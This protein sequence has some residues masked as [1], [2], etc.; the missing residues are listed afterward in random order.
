MIL[1]RLLQVCNQGLHHRVHL[2]IGQR[3]LGP[4]IRSRNGCLFHRLVGSDLLFQAILRSQQPVQVYYAHTWHDHM[5]ATTPNSCSREAC[6]RPIWSRYNKLA[7]CRRSIFA[8]YGLGCRCSSFLRIQEQTSATRP[9]ATSQPCGSTRRRKPSNR[10]IPASSVWTAR[11]SWHRAA[12][13]YIYVCFP[14]RFI[15]T[16]PTGP[17]IVS[18]TALKHQGSAGLKSARST[19]CLDLNS[20]EIQGSFAAGL[21]R[22]FR[23][24]MLWRPSTLRVTVLT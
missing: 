14:H 23:V 7:S 3:L 16:G 17:Q 15:V 1:P 19:S 22:R 24:I 11:S 2:W 6:L 9:K 20:N 12:A 5:L 18:N 21:R 13:I 4:G 8:I 10:S